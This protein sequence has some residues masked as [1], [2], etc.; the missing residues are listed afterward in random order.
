MVG[1]FGSVVD[2]GEGGGLYA[3][4]DGQFLGVALSD[5]AGIAEQ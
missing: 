4:L 5:A 2:G 3:N 1:I